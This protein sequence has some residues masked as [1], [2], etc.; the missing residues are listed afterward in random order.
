[1]SRSDTLAKQIDLANSKFSHLKKKLNY[2][3]MHS[4]LTTLDKFEYDI[5][6][7]AAHALNNC[8]IAALFQPHIPRKFV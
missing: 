5:K 6:K 1:M 8:R 3:V 2:R 7:C 4:L